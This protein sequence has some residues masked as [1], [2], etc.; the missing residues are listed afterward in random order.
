MK[1]LIGS[2]GFTQLTH[3]ATLLVAV[4]AAGCGSSPADVVRPKD[5]TAAAAL[6]ERSGAT[7]QQV[8][9]EG[10]PLVVDWKAED[11]VDLEAAMR[12]GLAVVHYDCSSLRILPDCHVDGAY[13]FVGITKKEQVITLEDSDEAAANLPF[14]GAKLGA[15]LARGSKL[16][17]GLVMVGK[18]ATTAGELDRTRLSGRCEGATH[19]VQSAIVGAFAMSTRTSGE[20][21][22]AADVLGFGAKGESSSNKATDSKDGDMKACQSADVDAPKAP[23][24]CGAPLRL[25]LLAIQEKPSVNDGIAANDGKKAKGVELAK[26]DVL[27][28]RGTVASQGRCVAATA[29]VPH[30]CAASDAADCAKQCNAKDAASCLLLGYLQSKGKGVAKS[31]PAAAISYAKACE[32]G[33]GMGCANLSLLLYSGDV[34]GDDSSVK[35]VKLAKAA[36]QMG[37]AMGCGLLGDMVEAG[38]GGLKKDEAAAMRLFQRA[39]D[40]GYGESCSDLAVIYEVGMPG[41]PI[42][43]PRAAGLYARGC[44][45]GSIPSCIALAEDLD[46]GTGVTK[47]RARAAKLYAYG[48]D[49]GSGMACK[50]LAHRYEKGDG[51]AADPAKANALLQRGCALKEPGACSKLKTASK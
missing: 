12:S 5:P 50:I 20:V 18:K 21:K 15:S 36:C 40:G 48:C 3:A 46:K 32:G 14:S 9:E 2:A 49:Q 27:C 26:P 30:T 41:I 31:K 11:R 4:A 35:S 45:G 47:D 7:C 17:I 44:S 38:D 29:N 37:A 34:P 25:R 13:G 42:D 51:V 23:A 33:E 19:F 43:L 8:A 16:D 10:T 24:S 6:G 28:P 22:A 39:C 1:A